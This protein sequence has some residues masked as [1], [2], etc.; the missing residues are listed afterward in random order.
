MKGGCRSH[1]RVARSDPSD[2]GLIRLEAAKPT[3]RMVRAGTPKVLFRS[4]RGGLTWG[5]V[6]CSFYSRSIE[7][8]RG[9]ALTCHRVLPMD[10]YAFGLAVGVP[11]AGSRGRVRADS[12]G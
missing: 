1:L 11:D 7:G 6:H 12:V 10:S 3:S 2:L 4:I 5:F 9:V 8:G